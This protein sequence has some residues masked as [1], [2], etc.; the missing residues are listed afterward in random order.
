MKS[1][2]LIIISAL[3]S[4][5]FELNAQYIND[6]LVEAAENNPGLKS[7]YLEYEAAMERTAQ[8]K[9]LPDLNL[10]F[11]YFINP[12][13]TRV[14]PQ[15]A[16]FSLTQMFPWFGTNN[17]IGEIADLN[18]QSKYQEF[19]DAMNEL[20]YRVKLAYYPICEINE[21]IKWQKENLDIL[22]TY[23]R[24]STSNFSA[25]KSDMVDV[26][27]VDIMIDEA[28]TELKLLEDQLEPLKIAFNRLLSRSDSLDV[29]VDNSL[30][31]EYLR[32]DFQK[33][34]LL[35]NNPLLA[36]YD[37]KIKSAKAHEE[38]VNRQGLPTFGLGIDYVIID[39]RTDVE[40]PDNGKNALMPMISMSLPIFRGKYK[41]SVKEAQLTQSALVARKSDLENQLV[42]SFEM[43]QYELQKAN[44]LNNLY[45]LQITKTRQAIDL[46]FTAYANSGKDFEEVLRMQQELIKYEMAK[47]TAIKNYYL[48]LARI[49]YIIV[50]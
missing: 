21:Q 8:V 33:D 15:R 43:S 13:E 36:S 39:K 2:V 38:T 7:I 49:D 45:N 34:S 17:S 1:S 32:N 22:K 12:V 27:R 40:M 29:N 23:K 28:E 6:Y 35:E 11:G 24:L 5:P 18:A 20:Y 9:A 42:S 50:K 26:I 10:S 48:A 44:Q 31:I 14:G 19:L 30:S 37:L 41:A 3:L 4:F 47:V 16:K 46:L 25:G